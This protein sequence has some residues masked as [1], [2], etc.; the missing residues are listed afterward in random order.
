LS[1][2]VRPFPDRKFDI[3]RY[4]VVAVPRGTFPAAAIHLK[5]HTPGGSHTSSSR[6]DG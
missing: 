5:S 2:V 6:I 4:G 1:S 3:L